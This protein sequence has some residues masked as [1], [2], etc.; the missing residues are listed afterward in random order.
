MQDM[1]EHKDPKIQT[2]SK[3]ASLMMADSK[4]THSSYLCTLLINQ[5]TPRGVYCPDCEFISTEVEGSLGHI[6]R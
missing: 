5:V 1:D 3:K 2:V 6:C 4:T